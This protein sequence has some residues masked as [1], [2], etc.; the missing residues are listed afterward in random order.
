[1]SPERVRKILESY[2]LNNDRKN[3]KL[4]CNAL[5][6]SNP[7]RSKTIEEKKNYILIIG[8]QH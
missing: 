5:I 7:H 3:F 4:V 2:V 8:N 6:E 1:M